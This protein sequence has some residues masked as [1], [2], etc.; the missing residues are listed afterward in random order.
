MKITVK[1]D[2][3]DL[4]ENTVATVENEISRTVVNGTLW[5]GSIRARP[6]MVYLLW[7][8]SGEVPVS[9]TALRS[10]FKDPEVLGVVGCFLSK[11][12]RRLQ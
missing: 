3:V 2:S 5:I 6:E 10:E 12:Q 7:H 4:P 11:W 9:M 1:L 8:A